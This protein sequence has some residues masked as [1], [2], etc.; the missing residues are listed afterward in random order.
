MLADLFSSS[1]TLML[2]LRLWSGLMRGV[3]PSDRGMGMGMM[4]TEARL[5]MY[6]F[7]DIGRYKPGSRSRSRSLVVRRLSLTGDVKSVMDRFNWCRLPGRTLEI[8]LV[9]SRGPLLAMVRK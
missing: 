1:P 4:S 5:G 6:G 7:G 8:V 3:T 2:G 9:E